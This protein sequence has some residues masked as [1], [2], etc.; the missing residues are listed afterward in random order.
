MTIYT[1]LDF[2]GIKN[3]LAAE[4]DEWLGDYVY[5]NGVTAK[6]I[7][8]DIAGNIPTDGVYIDVRTSGELDPSKNGLEVVLRPVTQAEISPTMNRGKS[9]EIESA[10]EFKQWNPSRERSQDLTL[11]VIQAINA[12]GQLSYDATLRPRVPA[13]PKLGNIETQS[14]EFILP[15]GYRT[16][17]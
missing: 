3:T 5:P 6:A 1:D 10:I 8:V 16:I 17:A 14:I 2:A 11:A 13:D 15:I 9:W 4:L 12:V 7:A